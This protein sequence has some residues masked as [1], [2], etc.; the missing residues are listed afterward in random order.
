MSDSF[1][2]EEDFKPEFYTEIVTQPEFDKSKFMAEFL[3]PDEVMNELIDVTLS[4]GG[5]KIRFLLAPSK[6]DILKN[7]VNIIIKLNPQKSYDDCWVYLYLLIDEI[8][9]GIEEYYFEIENDD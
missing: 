4:T 1:E 9:L 6:T 5:S 8:K 3:L 7:V 2:F